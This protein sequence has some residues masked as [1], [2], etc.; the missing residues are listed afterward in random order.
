MYALC[1][2]GLCEHDLDAV[3]GQWFERAFMTR[4]A[5]FLSQWSL[6]HGN[7]VTINIDGKGA[8]EGSIEHGLDRVQGPMEHLS[9]MWS[10]SNFNSHGQFSRC[11]SGEACLGNASKTSY[12]TPCTYSCRFQT[13]LL[14]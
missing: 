9:F 5:I 1:R 4:G 11:L 13:L 7:C 8:V 10:A 3:Q 6:Y 12:L 14:L 2:L